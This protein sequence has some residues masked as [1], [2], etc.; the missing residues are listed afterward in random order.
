MW[1]GELIFLDFLPV[2]NVE[3][4][5]F[6]FYN[7]QCCFDIILFTLFKKKTLPGCKYPR[8]FGP[9]FSNEMLAFSFMIVCLISLHCFRVIE[10]E[11]VQIWCCLDKWR[12][13]VQKQVPLDSHV[14]EHIYQGILH[15]IQ[16][17]SQRG[18]PGDTNYLVE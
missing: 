13:G 1:K 9:L 16:A 12:D 6:G 2:A 15:G 18:D 10:P 11:N 4:N 17:A 14:Y 5:Q 3:K 8:K 7:H